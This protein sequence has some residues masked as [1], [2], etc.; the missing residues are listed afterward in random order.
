MLK[1]SLNLMKYSL[2]F[3]MAA[4]FMMSCQNPDTKKT[5]SAQNAEEIDPTAINCDGI[6]LVKLS[7]SKQDLIEQFGEDDLRDNIKEIK[8]EKKNTTIVFPD[9]PEEVT[10]VWE[11]D[12][13]EKAAKLLIWNENG[14]YS[15]KEGLRLGTD[16]RDIVKINNF[17]S[18]SFTNFYVAL[19][20]YADITGFNGGVIEEEY[21]CLGGR[22]DIV[23]LK[24]IDKNRLDEFKE[25]VE[26]SSGHPLVL[27]MDVKITE[28][29]I[30]EKL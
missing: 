23:R 21:P 7:Y 5:E 24:G 6:G 22:L 15:T 19:D 17:P 8:G 10:V 18:V 12:S 27:N 11:D 30:G 14:P 4:V 25:E 28:I 16:L 2:P 26:V 29:S 20:G 1:T 3:M 13:Q 9:K